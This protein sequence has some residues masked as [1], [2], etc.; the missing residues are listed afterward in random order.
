MSTIFDRLPVGPDG[1][2]LKST[3]RTVADFLAAVERGE[4]VNDGLDLVAAV[5]FD[6][7]GPEGSEGLPLVRGKVRRPALVEAVSEP[8]LS[9]LW[10]RSPRPS[11]LALSAGLLQVLDAWEASHEA[12]QE[13]DDL[14]EARTSA[15]W[16]GIAH[17]R[18]PDPGN[19]SYW[20]RRVGRHAIFPG[21]AEE[22]RSILGDS[23]SR[24]VRNAAWDPFAFIAYCSADGP[25]ARRVQRAEMA[26]LLAASVEPLS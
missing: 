7:L 16:H 17:R 5:A 6:G 2:I 11:V 18:E 24:L 20:F 26:R 19:A 23:A 12:A 22:A 1:A 21:L 8:S 9:R 4:P 10:P 3:G 15:Y 14:G 13:A 25:G